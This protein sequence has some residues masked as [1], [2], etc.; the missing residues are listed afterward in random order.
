VI[1][2]EVNYGKF[3]WGEKDPR[4]EK[5]YEKIEQVLTDP[6]RPQRRAYLALGRRPIN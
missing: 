4:R 3:T 5:L 6:E 1:A 2:P